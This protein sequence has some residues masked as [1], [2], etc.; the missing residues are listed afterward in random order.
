MPFINEP[1][2]SAVQGDIGDMTSPAILVTGAG[3]YIG[4]RLVEQLAAVGVR[5][6]ALVRRPVA[7]AG[8]GIEGRPRPEGNRSSNISSG[9][10]SWR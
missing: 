1:A 2:M 3:G 7:W 4:Q 9:N 8:A 5:V 6:R 10:S